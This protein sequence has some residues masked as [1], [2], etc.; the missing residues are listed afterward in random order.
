MHPNRHRRPG[1]SRAT[2][3]LLHHLHALGRID[4]E[5][6]RADERLA[7]LL[8]EAQ[9][10]TVL[11]RIE[12]V[13]AD[14]FSLERQVAAAEAISIRQLLS[15]RLAHTLSRLTNWQRGVFFASLGCGAAVAIIG[16][17]DLVWRVRGIL[18]GLGAVL[19]VLTVYLQTRHHRVKQTWIGS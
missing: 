2:W 8:G 18:G 12:T 3:R 10:E 7:A 14:V 15:R 6:L 4:T 11:A 9:L 1:T 17:I 13:D 5:G 16:L 19:I